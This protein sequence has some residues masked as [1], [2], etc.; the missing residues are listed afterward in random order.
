MR[1][2]L[3]SV[4]PHDRRLC[5]VV[6]GQPRYRSARRSLQPYQPTPRVVVPPI[7]T[8]T[9]SATPIRMLADASTT[10]PHP[11]V[12]TRGGGMEKAGQAGAITTQNSSRETEQQL[13]HPTTVRTTGILGCQKLAA[14]HG[15]LSPRGAQGYLVLLSD[16]PLAFFNSVSTPFIP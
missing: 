1:E 4:I 6:C 12:N 5:C 13:D 9:S 15:G 11:V 7:R 14:N 3:S 10:L 2:N 16:S 8:E